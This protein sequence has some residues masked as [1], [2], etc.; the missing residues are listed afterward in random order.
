MQ[1]TDADRK[2]Y[3]DRKGPDHRV[4]ERREK[5]MIFFF[6]RTTYPS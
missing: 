5:M 1:A 3:T 4:P 2:Y 6:L